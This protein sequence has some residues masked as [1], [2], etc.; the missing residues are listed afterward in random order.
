[1]IFIF[2]LTYVFSSTVPGT[3]LSDRFFNTSTIAEKINKNQTIE[4]GNNHKWVQTFTQSSWISPNGSVFSYS[5][6]DEAKRTVGVYKNGDV[7]GELVPTQSI[8]TNWGDITGDSKYVYL[9]S[10]ISQGNWVVNGYGVMRVDNKTYLWAGFNSGFGD[11]SCYFKVRDSGTTALYRHITSDETT[12]KLFVTDSFNNKNKVFVFN[13]NPANGT[14]I[15]SFDLSGIV[16]M[17]AYNGNIWIIIGNEIRKYTQSGT[18]TNVK[19]NVN[20]ATKIQINRQN[21]LMVWD[22]DKCVIY[23]YDINTLKLLKTFGTVGG[24]YS[25][26]ILNRSLFSV[27]PPNLTGFGTDSVGNIYLTW[28]YG[29]PHFTDI[30]AF[31]KTGD[32]L[33]HQYNSSF[34]CVG[35]LDYRKDG[36]EAFTTNYKFKIDWTKP[37][38]KKSTL[39]GLTSDYKNFTSPMGGRTEVRYVNNKRILIKDNSDL[40]GNGFTIYYEDGLFFK[41]ART[42]SNGEAKAY[43]MDTLGNVWDA[44]GLAIREYKFIGFSGKVPIWDTVHY[45]SYKKEINFTSICRIHYEPKTDELILTGYNDK[46]PGLGGKGIGRVIKKYINF[47]KP[48]RKIAWEGIINTDSLWMEFE[49]AAIS[50]E[51]DYIFILSIGDEPRTLD[52]YRKSNFEYV[53]KIQPGEEIQGNLCFDGSCGMIGWID[54]PFGMTT[55]KRKNGEYVILIENDLTGNNIVYRWCPSGNCSTK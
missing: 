17:V 27:F 5:N 52:V 35:G 28:G 6:W 55:I 51:G 14:A 11:Y 49:K 9:T 41:K 39:V 18:Y 42:F 25:A 43:Y 20:N 50:I 22:N 10:M 15:D 13:T 12:N 1:M 4:T 37:T 45:T 33:Y 46:Y 30:R 16:D 26:T 34:V 3:V 44:T 8:T 36:T 31:S 24:Y 38:D 40:Y 23:F 53:G 32:S 47:K 19:I 48:T 2:I 21:Q 54:T 7:V 29:F